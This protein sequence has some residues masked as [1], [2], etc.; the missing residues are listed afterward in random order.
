MSSMPRGER[1]LDDGDSP[2]LVFAADLRRLRTNAGQPSYREL[3]RRAH[4]SASTSRLASGGR[5]SDV[6][7]WDVGTH[8][9]WAAL[10]GHSQPITHLAWRPDGTAVVSA[11]ADAMTVW[12]LDV[13]KALDV[14]G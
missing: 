1:P 5:D 2:L 9:L 3:S 10:R 14:L 8:A 12:P 6:I 7:V 13:E 4:F 11:G